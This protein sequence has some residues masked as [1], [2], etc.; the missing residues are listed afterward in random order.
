M[1]DL[2][3]ILREHKANFYK[4]Y[5]LALYDF[6]TPLR[7][8]YL[9]ALWIILSPLSQIGV[10]WFVFGLGIRNG[11]PIDGHPFLLWMLAG[12]IPWFYISASISAGTLAI[13]SKAAII[14][15]MKFPTSIIPTNTILTQLLNNIPLIFIMILSY[16]FNGYKA[17]IYYIQI[18]YYIIAATL[19]LIGISL[20]TSALVMAVRD[21]NRLV[22]TVL[23]FMFYLTPILW[24]TI[25]LPP[26]GLKIIRLNPFIYIIEGFRN[27]FLY[28]KWFFEDV[29][30]TVYYWLVTIITILIGAMIHMK[31]RNRFSD[32]V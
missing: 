4:I 15:K 29:K 12:L 10:Y 3:F 8:T 30:F 27:T 7:D 13:Y 5:K 26:I 32:L 24:T 20:I 6:I 19:L 28:N 2:L 16:V 22:G 23:R 11:K 31:F 17:T 21:I 14:T 9:G 1:R 25:N 18:P